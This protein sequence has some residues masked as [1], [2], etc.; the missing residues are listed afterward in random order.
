[1][2]TI[3]F[4]SI[5]LISLYAFFKLSKLKASSRQLK[6]NDRINRFD[7]QPKENIIEGDSEKIKDSDDEK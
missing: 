5:A 3:I 7:H 6:R 4:G 1:M 2:N